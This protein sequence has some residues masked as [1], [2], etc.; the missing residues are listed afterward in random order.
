MSPF[1][2]RSVH[3]SQHTRQVGSKRPKHHSELPSFLH[4]IFEQLEERGEDPVVEASVLSL[5]R[6][7]FV[8]L[9]RRESKNWRSQRGQVL[10]AQV[11]TPCS[12]MA[13]L[14]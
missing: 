14:I 3:R 6:Q 13:K 5:Y 11:C 7:L 2:Q 9:Q 12:V 4:Q 8:S 1:V 10:C